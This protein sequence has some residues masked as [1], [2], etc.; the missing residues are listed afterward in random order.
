MPTTSN[1][2]E[3]EIT[4]WEDYLAHRIRKLNLN[5]YHLVAVVGHLEYL[6]RT[7]IIVYESYHGVE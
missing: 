4:A 1:R 3:K 6:G 2:A 5:T 7:F